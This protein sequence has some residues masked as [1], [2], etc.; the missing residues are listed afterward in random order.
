MQDRYNVAMSKSRRHFLSATAALMAAS[1]ACDRSLPRHP[2][3]RPPNCPL[4]RRLR[5]ALRPPPPRVSSTTFEE[6]EKLVQ[7]P[8]SQPDREQAS[9]NW[10][11]AM[12]FLYERHHQHPQSGDRAERV[13]R[14]ALGP[15]LL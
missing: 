3:G 10:R 6:A 13:A 11:N 5:S 12:A 15:R 14:L 8:M 2:P 1:A 7:F 4:E 9:G